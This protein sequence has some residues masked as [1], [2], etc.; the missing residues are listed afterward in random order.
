MRPA[1]EQSS[2]IRQGEPIHERSSK[3]ETGMY[4]VKPRL[5]VHTSPLVDGRGTPCPLKCRR[6]RSSRPLWLRR[7]ASSSF[8]TSSG[9]GSRQSLTRARGCH[10]SYCACRVRPIVSST[11]CA[12][13]PPTSTP[14]IVRTVPGG[15]TTSGGSTPK[16]RQ[17][18]ECCADRLEPLSHPP[19]LLV[20]SA[21]AR[22]ATDRMVAAHKREAVRG[23]QRAEPCLQSVSVDVVRGRGHRNPKTSSSRF[24]A[25]GG[26]V[27]HGSTTFPHE[28]RQST[29]FHDCKVGSRGT[30]VGQPW[31]SRGT[32]P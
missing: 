26:G 11:L 29:M 7:R 23:E 19:P 4:C 32:G 28:S 13:S 1:F 9:V 22:A 21:H 18:N 27:V 12:E 17:R 8:L 6:S 31:N 2:T 15:R 16:F 30:A 3:T 10:A 5:K 24:L 25:P 14:A 20:P